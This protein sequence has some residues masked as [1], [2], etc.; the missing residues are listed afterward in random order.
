MIFLI[1]C[2]IKYRFHKLKS[3]IDILTDMAAVQL[4]R[5]QW[6]F[7]EAFLAGFLE[8]Q[9]NELKKDLEIKPIL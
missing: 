2:S 5:R 7:E 1:R 6:A 8:E 4:I 3:I 9:A